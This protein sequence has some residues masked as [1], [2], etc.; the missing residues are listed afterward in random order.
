VVPFAALKRV[1]VSEPADLRDT[2]WLPIEL[3]TRSGQTSMAFTPVL[4][5]GTEASG[6]AQLMLGRRTDW[7]EGLAGETGIGQRVLSSDGPENGILAVRD[8]R[9][10]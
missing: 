10:D 9:L 1:R 3:E 8:I 7:R 5:P 4:Y 2:V 6:D